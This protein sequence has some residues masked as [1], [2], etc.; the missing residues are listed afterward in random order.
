MLRKFEQQLPPTFQLS[1]NIE[2]KSKFYLKSKGLANYN[3]TLK[4]YRNK[5]LSWV[6]HEES[7]LDL[8][9]IHDDSVDVTSRHNIV[10]DHD[11]AFDVRHVM[12]SDVASTSSTLLT[13]L[14]LHHVNFFPEINIRKV[15]YVHRISKLL[16]FLKLISSNLHSNCV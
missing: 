14:T 5:Y 13:L 9:P 15:S 8:P 10:D 16:S 1:K 3:I 7:D 2:F 4:S 12:P 6:G 11:V